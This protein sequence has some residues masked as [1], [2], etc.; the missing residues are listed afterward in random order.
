VGIKSVGIHARKENTMNKQEF[1]ESYKMA[2]FPMV[3]LMRMAPKDKLDWKP[4][5]KSWTLG[6]LLNHTS[7]A[8]MVFSRIIDNSWPSSE[9]IQKMFA[10]HLTIKQKDGET[11]AKD[12][13]NA[14]NQ[15]IEKIAK[16]SDIDFQTKS[17]S[18]PLG[19]SGSLAKV[20]QGA[21]D[22]QLT[23]KV[24]LFMYLKI[25][26]LPVNTGTLYMGKSS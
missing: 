3:V 19:M 4:T 7:N 2:S 17:A 16:V 11:A 18:T 22:H 12:F 9:E 1:I 10:N 21:C 13:E 25:L 8:P 6:Q 5:E 14:V 15:A 26:G 23:H 24:Q 20:L